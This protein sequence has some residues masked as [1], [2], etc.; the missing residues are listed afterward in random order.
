MDNAG[1]VARVADVVYFLD[2]AGLQHRLV[3]TVWEG[4]IIFCDSSQAEWLE[5]AT[6]GLPR[7]PS[8]FSRDEALSRL[9][10]AEGLS[11][12]LRVREGQ[13]AYSA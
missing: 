10:E 11:G 2:N 5:R 3:A 7:A 9:R 1:R 13:S 12:D 4:T 6:A 8:L